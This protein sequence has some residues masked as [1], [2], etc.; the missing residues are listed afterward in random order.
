MRKDYS[1]FLIPCDGDGQPIE[2]EKPIDIEGRYKAHYRTMTNIGD[3]G[4][5]KNV[6][7]EDYAESSMLRSYFP[8]SAEIT[9]K[10][11]THEL[12]L[13][14]S[15][16]KCYD[17]SL[18]FEREVMGR[19]FLWFDSFRH[20]FAMVAMNKQPKKNSERLYGLH[21]YRD[22][23]Y[24]FDDLAGGK[25]GMVPIVDLMMDNIKAGDFIC[26]MEI[27][28]SSGTASFSTA[29]YVLTLEDNTEIR[30]TDNGL[31]IH[32]PITANNVRVLDNKGHEVFIPYELQ[33][34]YVNLVCGV[35]KSVVKTN[36]PDI[37]RNCVS[38]T[39]IQYD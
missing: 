25:G 27:E 36:L 37:I 31:Q 10:S 38:F 2:G 7:T 8:P 4:D 1:F 5:V 12:T 23:T 16:E 35:V 20:Q 14:F 22:M 15:G 24:T 26:Q 29:N 3:Y 17:N 32:H 34:R 33:R 18:L 19:R 30:V 9:H 13:Y 28:P 39:A 21:Q 11:T 6:Y